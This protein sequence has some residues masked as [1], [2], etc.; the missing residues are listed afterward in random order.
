MPKCTSVLMKTFRIKLCLFHERGVSNYSGDVIY[1]VTFCGVSAVIIFP[2]ME[3]RQQ[4]LPAPSVSVEFPLFFDL[5]PVS[6]P[7]YSQPEIT[8][9][10]CALAAMLL[11]ET[12]D[13]PTAFV[14]ALSL[15]KLSQHKAFLGLLMSGVIACFFDLKKLPR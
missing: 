1:Y 6:F 15:E 5:A 8:A 4:I 14:M 9:A 2:T 10:K 3:A 7:E 13:A 12:S 11:N